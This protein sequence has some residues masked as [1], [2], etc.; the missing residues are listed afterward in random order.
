M[1]FIFKVSARRQRTTC[2]TCTRCAVSL[3]LQIFCL[4]TLLKKR[5]MPT[6][7]ASR[8]MPF[9]SK[10]ARSSITCSMDLDGLFQ[11]PGNFAGQTTNTKRQNASLASDKWNGLYSISQLSQQV[12][13][14]KRRLVRSCWYWLIGPIAR[15]K[16]LGSAYR[17]RTCLIPGQLKFYSDIGS[18]L[19]TFR[20]Q[21]FMISA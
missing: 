6:W 18:K 5:K 17:V 3:W 10:L 20:H 9:N 8:C 7:M 14:V 11:H 2:T 13:G 15:I 16:W 19:L 4:S 12:C 1:L 21:P